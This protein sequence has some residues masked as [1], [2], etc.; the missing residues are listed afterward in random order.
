[1]SSGKVFQN[2]LFKEVF[3]E[4]ADKILI[5]TD[6]ACSGNPGRGGYGVVVVYPEGEVQEFGNRDLETTNNRMEMMAVIRG[7]SA[8]KP[9]KKDIWILTD[10]TYVIRGITQWI[11]GWKKRGWKNAEGNEVSNKDLWK[12]LE[13]VVQKVQKTNK[14]EWK[15]VRGHS[16][17]PGNERCDEIAVAF[18]QGK[19]VDLYSGSL[20]Q[21]E[22]AVYDIPD[23][24]S[25]PPPKSSSASK[26]KQAYS[27]LSY[28]NGTFQRHSNWKDCEAVVKGRPGAKFKKALSAEDE[29][30]IADSWGLKISQIKN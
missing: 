1:M 26:K 15:Y 6:G 2:C 14:I 7:L 9:S 30:T 22:Y 23:D 5:F 17:T 10:S 18:T 29:V 11:W 28:V 3:L 27:Y 24:L 12:K 13:A 19:W 21:Y 16:G 20:L 25:L 4:S 8:M